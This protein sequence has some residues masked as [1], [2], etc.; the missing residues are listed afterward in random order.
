[1]TAMR[2]MTGHG[3]GAAAS[4]AWQVTVELKSV[5]HRFLD[6]SCRLPRTWSFLEDTVRRELQQALRRGHVEVFL[7][8]EAQGDQNA[9]REVRVDTAL[10]A[11]YVDAARELAG[12][13]G[14]DPSLTMAQLLALEGVVETDEALPDEQAVSEAAAE[15]VRAAAAQLNAMREREGESLREDLS[16]HLSAAAA[17]RERILER[18]PTVV[19]SY[20]ARLNERLSRLDVEPVDPA[21]LA[22]EVALMADKC[23]IDEEL[24]RLSSHIGQM[25]GYLKASG[26]IGK[27]MDFLIQEMNR[28]AN[29]IGSKAS[30]AQIAQCVVD[31]KSEI[32]KLREQIQNVE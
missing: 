11:R 14:V 17:L 9:S 30:D 22:Q 26:E 23:A 32:E 10:A 28:E 27:K 19:E 1:M 15:A 24:A 4:G 12:A 18:A 3:K 5:N 21:R 31:L 13:T 16:A 2:S 29:T 25:T 8:V 7:S 20:R 6:I